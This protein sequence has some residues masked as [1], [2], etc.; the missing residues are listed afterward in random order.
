M[1]N[2]PALH[3]LTQ[4]RGQLGRVLLNVQFRART[5]CPAQSVPNDFTAVVVKTAVDFIVNN[6]FEFFCQ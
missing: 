4:Q 6:L 5:E 2:V 3:S 1:A